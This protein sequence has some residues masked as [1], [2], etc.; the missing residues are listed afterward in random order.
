M[1]VVAVVRARA[2][3]ANQTAR[4][5][6]HTLLNSIWTGEDESLK[7]VCGFE[8]DFVSRKPKYLVD[9]PRA[10]TNFSLHIRPP[11]V[12]VITARL[13]ESVCIHFAG[14]D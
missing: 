12:C 1:S 8:L 14:I 7:Y 11:P 6:L 5:R 4:K 9:G 2:I 10:L 13:Y 3:N